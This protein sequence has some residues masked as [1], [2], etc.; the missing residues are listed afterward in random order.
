[1]TGQ[2]VSHYR[3]LEKLGGGGM[4]VV[5]KA[6]DV[7]LHRHVALKFLPETLAK[8]RQALERF[9]REARAA[10]A[11]NHPNI[12]TV[13]E[14]SEHEGQPFIV[15]EFLEGQTLKERIAGK[16]LQ[17]DELL[18]LAVQ[19]SDALDAAH[20]KGIVHRDIKPA[21]LFVTQR[22]QAKI[23]DFGLAKIAP[24]PSTAPGVGPGPALPTAAEESITTTGIV[25]GTVEYMSPEQARGE[26]LDARTDL[27]SFGAVLYEMATGR[28]AFA[29]PS[30]GAIMEAIFS[31]TPPA[32]RQFNLQVSSAL[33]EI[34][35]KTL[36]KERERRYQTAAEL[37]AALERLKEEGPS[38]RRITLGD[39][40]RRRAA[41][42]I[43]YVAAA[44][45]VIALLTALAVLNVGGLR[46]QLSPR[47]AAPKIHSLAVLP[48]A[49]LSGDPDQEFFADGMTEEL[50]TNLAKISTLKVI[51]RTSMM[52]YK[53]TKKPLPQIA[54]ELNVD[55]LIE[56]SVLREGSRVRITA[57]LIQAA[58]DQHLWAESYER[59]LRGVLA[60]TSEVARAIASEIKIQVTPQE[61]ARLANVWPVNP[62]AHDAYLKGKFYLNKMTPEGFERGLGYLNQAIEMDPTSP[63]PYAGLALG[64]SLIG[65]EAIPDNLIA[66]KAAALKALELDPDLLEA[67]EALAEIKLY[68]DWDWAGAEQAFQHVLAQNTNLAEAHAH[69]SWCLE[70]MGHLDD[71]HAEMKRAVEVDPLTPLWPA[72]Q[73]WQF[74]K[75]G[76]YDKTL[77]GARKALELNPDFPWGLYVLGVGYAEEGMY[78]EAIAA[79]QKAA[80]V[81]PA[82]KWALGYTYA[83]A[84]RGDE[85]RKIA[86]E[87]KKKPM[88]MDT[89]G[90]AEIYTALGDKDEAFRWLDRCA[91]LRFTWM[92][93]VTNEPP[94]KPL[95]SDPRYKNLV[96]RMNLPE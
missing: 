87:L 64:Y 32:A 15:M 82:V 17:V 13:H 3:I 33:E 2:I 40:V 52:Q 31:R 85:A 4:G 94:F 37:K 43:P 72:W 36:Q 25:I 26:E 21:N 19:V 11:L 38:R 86:A 16:A 67:H 74:W 46:D 53:G 20:S 18:D 79:H 83:V 27:F 29:G 92:P 90:L 60:L 57:Q 89:W 5:Y 48:L 68:W 30:A 70:L 47:T 95:R 55:A 91:A 6:E 41:T 10:S 71:A 76:Q 93:W 7:K 75:T 59:D 66:A 80:A 73:G 81:S 44:V 62:E 54:K 77:V 34:V 23:L 58:T 49:N 63:L 65:H 56:G 51:S 61:Q 1:M 12:C 45:G 84:G 96:R 39:Y 14:I 28:Q 88:P 50:I 22:C 24:P 9:Q 42:T 78:E 8:D 35:T 69:Y